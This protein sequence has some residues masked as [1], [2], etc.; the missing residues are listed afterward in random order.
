[1]RARAGHQFVSHVVDGDCVLVV[2]GVVVA[3]V[4]H[5]DESGGIIDVDGDPSVLL[6]RLVS[7]RG[8]GWFYRLI[9]FVTQEFVHTL[10]SVNTA[11]LLGGMIN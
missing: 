2:C 10:K 6:C 11:S 3:L 7:V 9:G 8:C 5:V 4:G 1:M